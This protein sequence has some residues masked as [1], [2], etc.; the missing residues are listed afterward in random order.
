[1]TAP[2]DW[3]ALYG[4]NSPLYRQESDA[5]HQGVAGYLD[6]FNAM[7]ATRQGQHA[8]TPTPGQQQQPAGPGW[9]D[10][11]LVGA[12]T[13]WGM[14]EHQ[15]RAMPRQAVIEFVNSQRGNARQAGT[16]IAANVAAPIAQFG[17]G[18]V[19]AITGGIQHLPG[20]GDWLSKQAAVHQADLKIRQMEEGVRASTSG[21]GLMQGIESASNIAGNL[22]ATFLPATAAWSVAGKIGEVMPL[23]S[24]ASPIGRAMFNGGL[25][26]YMLAGGTHEGDQNPW[27]HRAETVAL[28]ATM[29]A[30]GGALG[31]ITERITQAFVAPELLRPGDLTGIRTPSEPA[32]RGDFELG[33]GTQSM[34]DL[35]ELAMSG[36]T[37]AQ[38]FVDYLQSPGASLH[39]ADALAVQMN[40][41]ATIIQSPEFPAISAQTQIDDLAVAHAA[42]SENPG[43]TNVIQGISDSALMIQQLGPNTRFVQRGT[44]LD[45]ISGAEPLANHAA[46]EYE[47][48][49]VFSG[50]KVFTSDGIGG[51]VRGVDLEGGAYVEPVYSGILMRRDIG[52]LH[53]WLTSPQVQEAPDLWSSFQGY[54]DQRAAATQQA[55]GGALGPAQVESVK[56]KNLA[57][58]ME[59]FFDA[60]GLD[61]PGD[62]DRVRQYFNQRWVDGFK[63]L[64]PEAIVQQNAAFADLQS[65]I[66]AN[67]LQPVQQLDQHAQT[68]GYIAVPKGTDGWT[69]MDQVTPT[70]LQ[71]SQI[72]FDTR[73]AA[74]TWLKQ[75][76]RDLPDIT[77]GGDV[78]PEIVAVHPTDPQQMPNLNE[79]ELVGSSAA[80]Q[81][82]EAIVGGPAGNEPPVQ[83][84]E[85]SGNWG[86]IR[87]RFEAAV[88]RFAPMRRVM[89][90][91]DEV[92]TQEGKDYGLASGYDAMS[93]Q[94]NIYHT[95]MEPYSAELAQVLAPV[96]TSR[97]ISGEWARAYEEL[98]PAKRAA[99]VAAK[100]WKSAEIAS[101]DGYDQLMQKLFPETSLDEIRQIPRYFSHI[102][103][104][105]SQPDLLPRAFEDFGLGQTTQP[106]YEYARTGNLNFRE[107]DPRIVG[108]AYIRSVFWQKHMAET[109]NGLRQHTA[110][111]VSNDPM[112]EQAANVMGSYLDTVRGGYHPKDDFALDAMHEALKKLVDP[113][114]TR[115]QAKELVLGGLN[116]S[117]AGLIGYRPNMIARHFLQMTYA[118]PR[119]G[120]EMVSV[121][122][123]FLGSASARNDI[124]TGAIMDGAVSPRSFT[125]AAPGALRTSMER[126]G[127]GLEDVGVAGPVEPVEHTMRYNAIAQIQ[128]RITD[129]VP[130]ALK[131]EG[132][133]LW[134]PMGAFSKAVERFRAIVYT[135]GKEK[136]QA[137]LAEFAAAGPDGDLQKLMGDSGARTYDP[138]W[139]RQFQQLV[140]SGDHEEAA[141]FMGR[142][143]SD[144]TF[145]KYGVT[146][147]PMA[148]KSVT[149]KIALQLGHYELNYIQMLR[150]SW[151][152]GT[153]GDKV[154]LLASI[155]ATTAALEGASRTTGWNFR[156]LNPWFAIGF[157]GGPMLGLAVA[158][159]SGINK[160]IKAAEGEGISNYDKGT[161]GLTQAAGA[162]WSMLSP[163]GGLVRGAQAIGGAMNSPYPGQALLRYGVTGE[164]G[165]G[166]DINEQLLPQAQQNFQNSLQPYQSPVRSSG[167]TGLPP[168]YAPQQPIIDPAI[169][170][171]MHQI[172]ASA[173]QGPG[174]QGGS[175]FGV[176][177]G[178]IAPTRR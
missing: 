104:R 86:R 171:D 48:Y 13:Y 82:M 161:Q 14:D 95:A 2:I 103:Q 145:F 112:A 23:V 94:Q 21:S 141:K 7:Q 19:E 40:K 167:G 101:L 20:V 124:L 74:E 6:Q 49:G 163:A 16:S 114:I 153:T 126:I 128:A 66:N 57:T 100:G 150:E 58:W 140:A 5:F 3:N 38:A 93:V 149:G 159:G 81:E 123:R 174:G 172:P 168:G 169:M 136:A 29:G 61:H 96:K 52:D 164:V 25:S 154:K 170:Q 118:I 99:F 119:A 12:A 165:P 78:P 139:Q 177:P 91:V 47:R 110:S 8:P 17:I 142:Q 147:S 32:V 106:F 50:Q 76:N 144:A 42:Q 1:M 132:D 116:S 72:S 79:H 166:P 162:G 31:K 133:S 113:A 34:P 121:L 44:R 108:D 26:A 83:V 156:W 41:A 73:E 36:N 68:K 51:T 85:A 155:G 107:L 35:H 46:L 4:V 131:G 138:A 129:A 37:Q 176:V 84:H 109:Y 63:E 43:G 56:T 97:K 152:N 130:D 77:P 111:I 30:V 53:P 178:G 135:A 157:G 134:R 39:R 64:A 80:T 175:G 9:T 28:G 60:A 120:P 102:A 117:Y 88:S 11:D 122:G 33:G 87:S 137:A 65:E 75:V 89:S 71:R 10:E 27:A 62:R 69:L 54:A 70:S 173:P 24:K 55:M 125:R 151:Q 59:D 127:N 158:A 146:E 22:S 92:A 143:L 115:G 160:M 90:A 67:P 105:Q 148:A 15:V 45:V 98:D 18:A